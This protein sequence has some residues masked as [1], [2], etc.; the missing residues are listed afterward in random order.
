MQEVESGLLWWG[1]VRIRLERR[2]PGRFALHLRVPSWAGSAVLRVNGQVVLED[3]APEGTPSSPTACGYNPRRARTVRIDRRWAP[4]DE[5]TADFSMS[6]RLLRQDRRLP[7]CGGMVALTRGPL[8]YCLE[9]V[10]HPGVNL[11]SVEVVPESLEPV[12]DEKKLSGAVVLRGMSVCGEPLRFI[13]YML[14]ANRD[15]SQMT[16][17]VGDSFCGS[18]RPPAPFSAI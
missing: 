4:G 1:Q 12:Y 5:L 8:V 17:F 18:Q 10:D 14:W 11:F 13:P 16:V 15:P 9:S 3:V 2:G 7:G 6:V